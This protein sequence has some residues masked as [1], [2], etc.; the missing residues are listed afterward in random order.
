MIINKCCDIDDID[1][2]NNFNFIY[3]YNDNRIAW[4]ILNMRGVSERYKNH[5]NRITRELTGK[6]LNLMVSKKNLSL[7]ISLND[8]IS[9]DLIIKITDN[10]LTHEKIKKKNELN[11]NLSLIEIII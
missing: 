8:K 7:M 1:L 11:N 3:Y 2:K 10:L 5:I 6:N 4:E 9:D